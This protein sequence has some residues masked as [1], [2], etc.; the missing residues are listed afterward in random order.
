MTKCYYIH[1]TPQTRAKT[2]DTNVQL[3]LEI[4][5]FPIKRCTE[6]KFLGV[7]IDDKLNW[8]AHIKYLKRKLSY[9]VATLSRI[10]EGIPNHLH[11]DL[12]YTLFESHLSYCISAWGSAAQFRIKT[13]W[14]TQK[15]CI[16]VLFGDKAAYLEKKEHLC[17]SKASWAAEPW[18]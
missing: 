16:R 2:E 12:Y 6:T 11:R 15:H 14:V 4:D 3:N 5:G 9:A 18:Y 10:R 13:L 7:I 17:M 1:F 8:D